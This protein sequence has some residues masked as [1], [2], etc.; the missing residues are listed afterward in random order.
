MRYNIV[1]SQIEA[2]VIR[3]ISAVFQPG[4]TNASVIIRARDSSQS[5]HS[6]VHRTDASAIERVVCAPQRD[7]EAR[8]GGYAYDTTVR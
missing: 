7:R 4:Y 5:G 3:P 1:K 8:S 6:C 2:F